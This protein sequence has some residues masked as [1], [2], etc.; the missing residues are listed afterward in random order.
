M[1]RFT[2]RFLL[3]LSVTTISPSEKNVNTPPAIDFLNYQTT[4]PQHSKFVI[5]YFA[6]WSIYSRGYLVSQV[7]AS[8]LTHLLYAFYNPVYDSV[9]YTASLVSLDVNADYNHNKSGLLTN[10]AVKGNIGELKLLKQDNPHLKIL[11]SVGGWTK[12]QHFPAIAASQNA[13]ETL[14]QSMVDFMTLYPWI[15]GMDLDWVQSKPTSIRIIRFPHAPESY[16]ARESF[17]APPA[18]EVGVLSTNCWYCA[19]L[20]YAC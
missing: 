7:E 9:N 19:P 8:K 10:E 13:R 2:L 16:I 5:G 17:C 12:S 6:Q 4:S 3:L 11:I 15:D 20:N 1:K 18:R 14:A